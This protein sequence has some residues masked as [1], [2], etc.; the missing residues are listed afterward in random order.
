MF[1]LASDN[2]D[3]LRTGIAVATAMAQPHFPSEPGRTSYASNVGVYRGEMAF[4][5]GLMHRFDRDFGLSA[6]VSFAGGGDAAVKAGV[7]GEF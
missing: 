4:S 1:D 5:A 7:A 2:R 6:G 3:E